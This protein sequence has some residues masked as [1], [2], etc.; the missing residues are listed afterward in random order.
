MRMRRVPIA[1]ALLSLASAA[2]AQNISDSCE[3]QIPRS[4]A[5]A[6]ERAFPGF[7]EPLEYDNAPEDIAANK[8]HD[9]FGCLG[10]ATGDFTGEGKKDYVIGMTAVKGGGG[11]AVIVLPKKGGWQFRKIQ[12]W[13]KHRRVSQ[14]VDVVPPGRYA[15]GESATGPLEK[16]ERTSLTCANS[17]VKIGTVE[18]TASIYCFVEGSLLHVLVSD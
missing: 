15:R 1:F 14:Y 9:G 6:L 18:A 2:T 17:G 12:I 7:R 13:G 16:D 11:L 10:V 3:M 8:F 4:L 5:N